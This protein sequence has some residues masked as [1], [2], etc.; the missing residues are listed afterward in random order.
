MTVLL[1]VIPLTASWRLDDFLVHSMLYKDVPIFTKFIGPPSKIENREVLDKFWGCHHRPIFSLSSSGN[2][3]ISEKNCDAMEKI[4]GGLTMAKTEIL[5]I[6]DQWQ[7]QVLFYYWHTYWQIEPGD[8][9]FR[10]ETAV[11][12]GKGWEGENETCFQILGSRVKVLKVHLYS[13]Y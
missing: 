5:R 8:C 1:T 3:G 12:L 4:F 6:K 7:R 2:S 10:L 13:S 11:W 9:M